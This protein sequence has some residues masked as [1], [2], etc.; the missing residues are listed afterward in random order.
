MMILVSPDWLSGWDPKS[1]V[2]RQPRVWHTRGFRFAPLA[3]GSGGPLHPLRL[4][5][6][7]TSTVLFLGPLV[8]CGASRRR[9]VD[10]DIPINCIVRSARAWLPARRPELTAVG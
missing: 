1:G 4:G 2:D 7:A 3:C 9:R 6:D 8:A 5:T 10:L